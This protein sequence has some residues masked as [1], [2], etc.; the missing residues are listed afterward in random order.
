M[1]GPLWAAWWLLWSTAAL[2]GWMWRREC[3]LRDI[4][5]RRVRA[6]SCMCGEVLA[7]LPVCV[8]VR[9]WHH[10]QGRCRPMHEEVRQ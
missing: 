9:G 2:L 6:V 5:E 7:V 1:S 3:Q 10:C 4:A 8:E